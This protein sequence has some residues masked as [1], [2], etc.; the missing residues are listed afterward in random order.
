MKVLLAVCLAFSIFGAPSVGAEE[1]AVNKSS[2]VEQI[3]K[4]SDQL[5]PI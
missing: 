2:T 1:L 5:P 4:L 3:V